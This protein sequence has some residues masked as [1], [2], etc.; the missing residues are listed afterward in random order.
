[1]PVRRV[2]GTPGHAQLASPMSGTLITD[3]LVGITS[4]TLRSG[5]TS[6]T[7]GQTFEFARVTFA[8]QAT[9]SLHP[10]PGGQLVSVLSGELTL[11]ATQTGGS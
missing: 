4:E 10:N 1:M 6:A 9:I 5:V 7:P 3:P 2:R 11:M 8:P